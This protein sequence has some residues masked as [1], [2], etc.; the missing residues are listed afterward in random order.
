MKEQS[1][2]SSLLEQG[3]FSLRYL[4]FSVDPSLKTRYCTLLVCVE[5]AFF[6]N[7]GNILI[8]DTGEMQGYKEK[9]TS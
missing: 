8:K 3:L 5:L 4:P 6:F 1:R 7:Y 2:L 9:D